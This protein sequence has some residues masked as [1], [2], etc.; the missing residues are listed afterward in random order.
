ME[1]PQSITPD[2]FALKQCTKCHLWQ[3]LDNY[4][5]HWRDGRASRCRT[6]SAADDRAAYARDRERRAIQK[7]ETRQRRRETYRVWDARY[8]QEHADRVRARQLL[9]RAVRDGKIVRPATCDGCG[10]KAR[11]DGHH[12]DYNQPLTVRWLCRQCHLDHHRAVG[13]GKAAPND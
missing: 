2:L 11:V 12:D 7:R 3:P 1:R 5:R 10:S 4:S 13:P 6:C 9:Q 8:K